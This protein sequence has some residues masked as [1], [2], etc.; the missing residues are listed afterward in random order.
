M[1]ID[2]PQHNQL[3]EMLKSSDDTS[4]ENCYHKVSRKA[5]E[6]SNNKIG[7]RDTSIT[8]RKTRVKFEL[9]VE[10]DV[11]SKINVMDYVQDYSRIDIPKRIF[12]QL[13][14]SQIT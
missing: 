13:D 14:K 4:L 5:T 9:P 1:H 12:S 11:T 8:P 2:C 3:K 10:S 6:M 7:K